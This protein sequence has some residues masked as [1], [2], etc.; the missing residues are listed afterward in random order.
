MIAWYVGTPFQTWPTEAARRW[1]ERHDRT[2]RS[3]E[4]TRSLVLVHLRPLD[5][6]P[7]H[8]KPRILSMRRLKLRVRHF[9]QR[10]AVLPS[11]LWHAS[12]YDQRNPRTR[13]S[14]VTHTP[15][16]TNIRTIRDDY[17]TSHV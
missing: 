4:T 16:Y 2:R 8:Q 6:L 5:L 13:T 1:T 9:A 12:A 10:E 7:R 11:P 14:G 15:R 17:G 3:S